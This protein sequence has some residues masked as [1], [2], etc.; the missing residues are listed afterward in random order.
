[1]EGNENF[2]FN[3]HDHER[4]VCCYRFN[5]SGGVF[6]SDRIIFRRIMP[7]AYLFLFAAM[8]MSSS[9]HEITARPQLDDIDKNQHIQ[10]RQSSFL[11]GPL[12]LLADD[13]EKLLTGTPDRPQSA[14]ESGSVKANSMVDSFEYAGQPV[15]RSLDDDLNSTLVAEIDRT[16]S[17]SI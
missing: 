3:F 15:P 1:M 7:S 13:N 11:E 8:T 12:S 17:L 4:L 14:G 9:L 6:S 2:F 10:I 5:F 16:R